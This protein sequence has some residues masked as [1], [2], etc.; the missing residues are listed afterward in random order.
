MSNLLRSQ[1]GAKKYRKYRATGVL[2]R[3]CPLCSKIAVETFRH[4]KIVRNDFPY[5]LIAKEHDMIV[6]LRHVKE[7][8]LTAHEL[9]EYG[10][11]KKDHLQ[12]YDY[13]IEP[14]EDAKSISKHFHLHLIIGKKN[15]S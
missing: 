5:D 14:H 4:W 8:G 7:E 6:P 10:V 13:I 1:D 12:K 3:G 15:I 9:K 2:E 11:I